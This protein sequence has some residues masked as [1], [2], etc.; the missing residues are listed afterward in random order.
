MFPTAFINASVAPVVGVIGRARGSKLPL[1]AGCLV[2]AGGLALLSALHASPVEIA[3]G[4]AVLG[5]GFAAA[6]AAVPNILVNNVDWE[7]TGA[8]MAVNTLAQNLGSSIGSQVAVTIVV[9]KSG[10]GGDISP[11]YTWAFAVAA[12][13]AALA[14]VACSMVVESAG[15]AAKVVPVEVPGPVPD[16]LP[17][18]PELSTE[19]LQPFT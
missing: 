19:S 11:G 15:T 5:V 16:P 8:A 13:A 10:A 14:F 9:A 4:C 2:A 7:Q 1:R 17:G 6:L 3:L 12:A 18:P